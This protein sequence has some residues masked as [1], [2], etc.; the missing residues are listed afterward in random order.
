MKKVVKILL[1]LSLIWSLV[2]TIAFV[3][4]VGISGIESEFPIPPIITII[5][6]FLAQFYCAGCAFTCWIGVP[7]LWN[8]GRDCG[9]GILGLSIM[10]Y[11]G[12]I[13]SLPIALIKHL[14]GDE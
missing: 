2:F 14:R 7:T 11:L 12:L 1:I 13:L 10:V 6:I 8:Y 5:L 3:V 9:F 4:N